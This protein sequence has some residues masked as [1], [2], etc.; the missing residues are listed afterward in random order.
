MADDPS[1][2]LR[3]CTLY[4]YHNDDVAEQFQDGFLYVDSDSG[5]VLWQCGGACTSW[6]GKFNITMDELTVSFDCLAGQREGPPR[7]KSTIAFLEPSGTYVGLDYKVRRVVISPRAKF[8]LDADT[9]AWEQTAEWWAPTS[10]EWM[11]IVY[12]YFVAP[13]AWTL[14]C[15]FYALCAAP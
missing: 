10:L 3:T 14:Q 15:I 2:T 4:G 6:H 1:C 5:L 8:I 11:H 7:L 12:A 13:A 9:G